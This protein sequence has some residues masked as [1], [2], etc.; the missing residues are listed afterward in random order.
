MGLI[1]WIRNRY[2]RSR[3]AKADRLVSKKHLSSA[4]IIYRKLL[5]RI[6]DALPHLA[7][8]YSLNAVGA[9]QN[10]S[11]LQKL[12]QLGEYANLAN[13]AAY[14]LIL[15]THVDD[16]GQLAAWSF[17]SGKYADAVSIHMEH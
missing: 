7:Q 4:E 14:E 13:K 12:E 15:K 16:I 10:I 17:E 2:Y 1:G 9:E 6:D 5:G 8:M 3:L 11:A